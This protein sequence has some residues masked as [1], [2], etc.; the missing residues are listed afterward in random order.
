M[1]LIPEISY[2]VCPGL[3]WDTSRYTR[4]RGDITILWW[5]WI[6]TTTS[7]STSYRTNSK[8]PGHG[9]GQNATV[10]S[11]DDASAVC[12]GKLCIRVPLDPADIRESANED[13]TGGTE[14]WSADAYKLYTDVFSRWVILTINLNFPLIY[15]RIRVAHCSA[16]NEHV[17]VKV[18]GNRR[19]L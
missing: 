8:C 9:N 17:T 1:S 6:T 7:T 3:L 5:V 16:R 18:Y 11:F 2:S 15:L 10:L 14:K 12:G 13:R 4:E 19:A